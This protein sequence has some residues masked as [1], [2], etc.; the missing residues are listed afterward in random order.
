MSNYK[1][2]QMEPTAEMVEAAEDAYMPFGDMDLALRMALLTAPDVQ[3]EVG[4]GVPD[5]RWLLDQYEAFIAAIPVGQE[6]RTRGASAYNWHR[7]AKATLES[8]LAAAPDVHGEPVAYRV[9]GSYTDLPFKDESSA[10]AYCRGLLSG[11]PEGGYRI[12]P[13]YAAPQPAPDVA[14]LVE[15]LEK[16]IR[17]LAFELR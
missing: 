7:A 14:R 1:L 3:G 13:L 16:E 8:L 2:M 6:N 10:K 11:D 4:E 9:T 17:A 5:A 12:T 15:A